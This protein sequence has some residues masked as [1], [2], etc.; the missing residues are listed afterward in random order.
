M[1][2]CQHQKLL[3]LVR[4]HL[5]SA[6]GQGCV[7]S[8]HGLTGCQET[9]DLAA[10]TI[11]CEVDS[12]ITWRTSQGTGPKNSVAANVDLTRIKPTDFLKT[13]HVDAGI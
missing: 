13:H 1:N 2:L 11:D 6:V 5:L 7:D 10:D 3:P 12:C 9:R 8:K 4:M